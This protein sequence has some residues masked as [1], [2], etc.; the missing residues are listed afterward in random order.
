VWELEPNNGKKGIEAFNQRTVCGWGKS[1][2]GKK[3]EGAGN[4]HQEKVQWG[5]DLPEV[6][7]KEG[8]RMCS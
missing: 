2:A 3:E 8:G 6:E 4:T 7:L 5:M 1:V